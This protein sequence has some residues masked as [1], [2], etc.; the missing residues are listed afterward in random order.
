[1]ENHNTSP[2]NNVSKDNL[3]S[4]NHINELPISAVFSN[5]NSNG[6]QI[7]STE[8]VEALMKKFPPGFRFYPTDYELIKYYLE[9]KL[10]NLPLQPN[11]IYEM[12]IYKYDPDTIAAYLKP[13]T[14]ENV[15]YVFTPRDRKYPN[16]ERPDRCTGNGYWKATGADI[17]IDD[18]KN[19]KIGS[20]RALVYHIG[21]PPKGKKTDWIM[22]EYMVPKIPIPNSST[23]RNPKLDEWVL[24]RFYN[25][26][27][28]I[29]TRSTRRK[30]KRGDDDPFIDEVPEYSIRNDFTNF[31]NNDN[32]AIILPEGT[33]QDPIRND[34]TNYLN[35]NNNHPIMF[36]EGTYQVPTG[37]NPTNYFIND[38][39]QVRMF[40]QGTD[41]DSMR[42]DLTNFNN[43]Y[44]HAMT[45]HPQVHSGISTLPQ[46]SYMPILSNYQNYVSDQ[47]NNYTG[48]A[49]LP[50]M[51]EPTATNNSI[52]HDYTMNNEGFGGDYGEY[53]QHDQYYAFDQYIVDNYE[54]QYNTNNF[55]NGETTTSNNS[56]NCETTTS[57]N[58]VNGE[59]TTSDNCET[60]T[61]NNFV[62]GETS[63]SKE[64]C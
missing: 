47:Y 6:D 56:I 37:N 46:Y 8:D 64:D 49:P 45:L 23:P 50:L 24:C 2:T 33:D 13:T 61:S 59:T 57:N 22:H 42:N 12:N 15:W 16:G 9:R 17:S 62:N 4:A 51:I 44:N 35:N 54:S 27:D 52:E 40:F 48:G 19:S 34:P 7:M 58:F 63:T 18:D 32:H 10:A 26:N 41:Q 38:N 25:K 43:N 29:T 3:I 53:P 55:V 20:R 28:V 31:N 5:K 36:S 11:K 14:A 30:R 39:N 60:N 21:K 1:M